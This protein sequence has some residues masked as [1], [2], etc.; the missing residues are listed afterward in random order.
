MNIG[1]DV[2]AVVHCENGGSD[3][4]DAYRTN[5]DVN[6]GSN[7]NDDLRI[8]I[9]ISMNEGAEENDGQRENAVRRMND[10]SEEND[11]LRMNM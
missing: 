8:H 3:E 5:I 7:G 4:N 6:D 9:G 11:G 1:L 10:S 2:K